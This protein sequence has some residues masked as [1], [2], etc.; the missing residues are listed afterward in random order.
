MTAVPD[1]THW[2]VTEFADADL[3]DLRRT[4]RLVQ[5]APVLAQHP[6][7]PLPEACGGSAMLKAAYRFLDTDD[8]EPPDFVQSHIEA[9]YSRLNAVPLGFAVHETT[10]A[11]WTG[12][13]AT[14]G[15]GPLGHTACHGLLGLTTSAIPPRSAPCGLA[16]PTGLGT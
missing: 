3:G 8:I 15:L 14:E 1:A 5:L 9:T 4:Q 13:R 7:A 6:G 2:A 16:G 11:D 10:A 12:L